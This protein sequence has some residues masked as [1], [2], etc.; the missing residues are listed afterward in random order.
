MFVDHTND[1]KIIHGI[2]EISGSGGIIIMKYG[3]LFFYEFERMFLNFEIVFV[4]ECDFFEILVL[5][6][7]KTI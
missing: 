3:E 7:F 6:T 1:E 5:R 2:I 4:F